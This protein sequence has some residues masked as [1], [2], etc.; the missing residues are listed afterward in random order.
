[1]I[2][3]RKRKSTSEILLMNVTKR[4]RTC[5]FL[6]SLYAERLSLGVPDSRWA[7]TPPKNDNKCNFEKQGKMTNCP[8]YIPKCM[9]IFRK[10]QKTTRE[11]PKW[12]KTK[13]T[14][15]LR[16]SPIDVGETQDLACHNIIALKSRSPQID[17]FWGKIFVQGANLLAPKEL[18]TWWWPKGYIDRY[19]TF[20]GHTG[21]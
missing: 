17:N 15:F 19:T 6:F 14:H 4:K 8:M 5:T 9:K 7:P 1:M 13:K 16:N 10:N 18:Y 2:V 3:F 11:W 12:L 20:W 21:P